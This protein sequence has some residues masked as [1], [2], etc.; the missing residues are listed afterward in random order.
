M[1]GRG[2]QHRSEIAE[3]IGPDGVSFV[4]EDVNPPL[5]IGERNVEVVEP[6]VDE[7]LSELV[8]GGNSPKNLLGQ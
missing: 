4:G 2:P 1:L 8:F 5:G 3:N 6:E 7:D